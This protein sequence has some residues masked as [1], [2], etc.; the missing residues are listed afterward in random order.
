MGIHA[1][2]R[3][4][5][6]AYL[7]ASHVVNLA[8]GEAF[9][10]MRAVRADAVIGSAYSMTACQPARDTEEDQ[11]AA[12]RWHRLANLWF[13]EPALRGRYPEAFAVAPFDRMG[14]R[15]DDLELV[16]APLDFIGI[17]LYTRTMIEHQDSDPLGMGARALFGPVAGKQGPKTD[18]GWEVWPDALYDVLVRITRDYDRPVIEITENGCSYLDGPDARGAIHDRRRIDFYRGYLEAVARAIEDGADVRGYHAW[19]L[20]DN[21]EWAEGYEQRFGLVWVDFATGER[22][23]KE[24]ARWY[25]RVAAENGFEA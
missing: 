17:N 10:A 25:G 5:L 7:R 2:G 23:L 21:F 1:P 3:R 15:D 12:E 11:A 20:L 6:A 9:R 19:S 13:L 18:F 14:I 8:Q 24:S 22:T 4:D 16:R